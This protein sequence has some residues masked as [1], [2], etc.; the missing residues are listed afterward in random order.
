MTETKCLPARSDNEIWENRPR[1]EGLLCRE[2]K[3]MKYIVETPKSVEQAVADSQAAVQ[4]HKF[5]VLHIHQP[6]LQMAEY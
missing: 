6:E 5:G 2:E 3:T 4:R 1:P